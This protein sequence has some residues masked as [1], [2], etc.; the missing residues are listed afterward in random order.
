MKKIK[1]NHKTTLKHVTNVISK[2]SH[3]NNAVFVGSFYEV[4]D[5][6]N[7]TNDRTICYG[8][9][10]VIDIQLEEINELIKKEIDEDTF[11]NF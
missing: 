3:D 10:E 1:S 6:G 11:L 7:I 8:P 2:W 5:E 9:K 4:D